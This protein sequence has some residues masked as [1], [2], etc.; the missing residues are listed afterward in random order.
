MKLENPITLL[1]HL[2]SSDPGLREQT[3]AK[4]IIYLNS[5]DPDVDPR[6]K[7]FLGKLSGYDN[8]QARILLEHALKV[9]EGPEIHNE[10]AI[11]EYIKASRIKEK[12]MDESCAFYKKIVPVIAQDLD[13]I[14]DVCSGNGLNSLLWLAQGAT[15][16]AYM[17][18]KRENSYFE[19]LKQEFIRLDHSIE[20]RTEFIEKDIFKGRPLDQAPHGNGMMVSVHACGTLTDRVMEISMQYHLPFAVMPCCHSDKNDYPYIMT[21]ILPYFRSD[22]A[23]DVMRILHLQ[24]NGYEII[25]RR[26]DPKITD[27]NLIMMGLPKN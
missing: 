5:I 10:N 14:I 20:N 7:Q 16:H 25:L 13:Y 18:D 2:N 22:D 27:K 26:I 12:E 19:G 24:N 21:E 11:R 4:L 3:Y 15:K 23:I 6:F 8:S 17:I 1:K 9:Q